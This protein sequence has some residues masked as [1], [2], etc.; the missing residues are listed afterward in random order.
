LKKAAQPIADEERQ[1]AWYVTDGQRGQHLAAALG[2]SARPF[3][4][5]FDTLLND[6]LGLDAADEQFPLGVLVGRI[7]EALR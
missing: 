1:H 4:G 2:L 6:L 3:G 5:V 7:G